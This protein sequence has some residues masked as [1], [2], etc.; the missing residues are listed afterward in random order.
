[1]REFFHG[2]RRKLGCVLLVMAAVLTRKWG[3]HPICIETPTGWE[4]SESWVFQHWQIAIALTLLSAY[5]I[6]WKP[7]KPLPSSAPPDGA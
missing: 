1:M 2:W 7:R 5:L 6:L 3:R 4:M